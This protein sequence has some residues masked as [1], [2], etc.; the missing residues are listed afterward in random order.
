MTTAFDQLC[1]IH[2]ITS[3][4][5]THQTDIVIGIDEVGRG[6]L[7]GHMTVAAAILPSKWTGKLDELDLSDTPLSLLN[8]SKKLTEKRREKL[9]T[10]ITTLSLAHSIV[11]VPI[12]V[13]DGINI[14]QATL[15]GMRLAAT[16]LLAH[17][18]NPTD[19]CILIDGNIKP[20]FDDVHINQCTHTLIKGDA[21]HSSIACASVIAKV[22]RDRQMLEYADV[23]AD[24]GIAK[25][26]GYPSPQH[27]K[28]IQLF[29]VLPEHRKSFK[30]IC[31]MVQNPTLG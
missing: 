25:N 16:S 30:P 10:P 23:Y 15:L 26:K 9:F 7:F 21:T 2:T 17:L 12:E 13:I 11:D 1:S 28:A 18:P 19:V 4:A 5:L 29:G 14:H 6:C 31:H 20:N 3:P 27:L 24:Y 22:H 8:D